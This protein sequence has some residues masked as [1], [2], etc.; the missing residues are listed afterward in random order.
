VLFVAVILAVAIS[1]YLALRIERRRRTPTELRG[2]WWAGF[3]AELRAYVGRLEQTRAP[4]QRRT[5]TGSIGQ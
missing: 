4:R 1:S 3:E 5:D 2:N